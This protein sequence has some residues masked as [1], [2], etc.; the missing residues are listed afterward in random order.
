MST[1]PPCPL[2]HAP[3]ARPLARVD[4]RSYHNCQLCGLAFLDP[5][6]RPW[7]EV[8][9]AEYQKHENDPADPGYRRHLAKAVD[10]LLD[11]LPAGSSGL[12]YGSGPGPTI[13]VM[14]AAHG[15]TVAE[16]DPFFNRD[17]RLLERGYDFITCTEVAEHFHDPADEFARLDRLLRPGGH[18]AVMTRLLTEAIDFARWH[19]IREVSHVVFY[20]PATMQ[21]IAAHHGW[22]LE[23]I[24]LPDVTLFAKPVSASTSRHRR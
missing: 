6:A 20:R 11:R 22:Q 23:E 21:W 18:L 4:G 10:P 15:H 2:C 1:P 13:G 5:A 12:D 8:E 9:R 14:M 3:K 19:Y 17:P 24:R 7:P 16:Y